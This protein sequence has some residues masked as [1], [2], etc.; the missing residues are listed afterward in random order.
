MILKIIKHP[1]YN[2]R[3]SGPENFGTPWIFILMGVIIPLK[4]KIFQNLFLFI[5]ARVSVV[6]RPYNIFSYIV[7]LY[8]LWSF[9][10]KKFQKVICGSFM[11]RNWSKIA[12][13]S[14]KILTVQVSDYYF[15]G[16]VYCAQRSF[17]SEPIYLCY[18][19][20]LCCVQIM[21]RLPVFCY[22]VLYIFWSPL[23]IKLIPRILTHLCRVDSSTLCL[24]T[25]PFPI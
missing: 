4:G 11:R 5:T 19:W 10:I 25:G 3:W 22:C 7:I 17:F 16:Y 20:C 15:C 23:I 9:V 14:K 12:N 6:W 24:W 18:C 13:L 1:V 8:T 2:T 21:K